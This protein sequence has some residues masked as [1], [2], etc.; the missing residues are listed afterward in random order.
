MACPVINVHQGKSLSMYQK[1][2]NFISCLD[3]EFAYNDDVDYYHFYA[4]LIDF[5]P[6]TS[7][8]SYRDMIYAYM[9]WN[10]GDD[11]V[12]SLDIF[13]KFIAHNVFAPRPID[14]FELTHPNYYKH[15]DTTRLM[16]WLV[17][18]KDI[19]SGTRNVFCDDDFSFGLIYGDN[20]VKGSCQ[21]VER[22]MYN[23]VLTTHCTVRIRMISDNSQVYERSMRHPTL[24]KIIGLLSTWTTTNVSITNCMV[25]EGMSLNKHN[26]NVLINIS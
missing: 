8:S 12:N 4:N 23:T 14:V 11:L 26:L 17:A 21:I 7:G 3:C 25:F 13:R 16:F 1:L 9:D 2:C 18:R 24:K 15:Y 19:P 6:L 5:L 10:S 22:Y 20:Y